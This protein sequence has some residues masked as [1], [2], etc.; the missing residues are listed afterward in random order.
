MPTIKSLATLPGC[1]SLTVNPAAF[2]AAVP[3]VKAKTFTMRL[4]FP[5]SVNHLFA[6]IKRKGKFVRIMSQK[7]K[8][9]RAN[10]ATTV[11]GSPMLFGPLGIVAVFEQPDKRLRDLDNLLKALLDSM[12]H[13]GLYRDDSQIQKI[14]ASF[15]G[16]CKGGSATV[17][18]SS[19]PASPTGEDEDDS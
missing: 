4:P 13:A 14:T 7:G 19:L 15:D 1:T 2:A 5:P 17:T 10:V 18:L 6:T 12:K 3:A 11:A 8:N 9:Y 16:Y